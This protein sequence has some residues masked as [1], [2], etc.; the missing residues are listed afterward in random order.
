MFTAVWGQQGRPQ[1]TGARLGPHPCPNTINKAAPNI[2]WMPDYFM[3]KGISV[4]RKKYFCHVVL[5]YS[6]VSFSINL[7]I[8]SHL[9]A[10]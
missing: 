7:G 6:L 3:P 1:P 2:R 4:S 8:K 5:G 10:V 9:T